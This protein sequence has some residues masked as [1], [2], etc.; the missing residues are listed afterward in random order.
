MFLSVLD[1]LDAAAI[2]TLFL[3]KGNSCRGASRLMGSCAAFK[4]VGTAE[5]NGTQRKKKKKIIRS[6]ISSGKHKK[7]ILQ[8]YFPSNNGVGSIN[9]RLLIQTR[10]VPEQEDASSLPYLLCVL[11]F[12]TE[13]P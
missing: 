12:F 8:V 3:P 7:L 2:L 1:Q 13:R 5:K 11:I 9:D 4:K 6:R 10:V